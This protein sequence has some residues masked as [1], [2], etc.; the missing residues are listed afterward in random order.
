MIDATRAKGAQVVVLLSHNGMDVDL[1][2]ATRVRGLDVILGGKATAFTF[3]KCGMNF[4]V[5]FV[6]SNP[7]LFPQPREVM[8][9]QRMNDF[10]NP[11]HGTNS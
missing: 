3:V 7:G 11:G 10:H 9:N 5:P 1:K 4:V 8:L 6:V 2:L